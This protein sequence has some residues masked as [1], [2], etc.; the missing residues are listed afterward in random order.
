M[1]LYSFQCL[2]KNSYIWRSAN[3]SCINQ[4]SF[5]LLDLRLLKIV[6][7]LGREYIIWQE[8]VDN[9]V[10]VLPD[11]VVNVW[12]GGWQNEMAKVTGK[13]LKAILSSC[14]YLNYIS[15]GQDWHK[16]RCMHLLS[17]DCCL[18]TAGFV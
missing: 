14:W 3:N 8:V 10:Q 16:V 7:G 17:R 11:T 18:L 2:L 15:Y 6:G 13:G 4:K 9:N 5:S 1:A 12:K